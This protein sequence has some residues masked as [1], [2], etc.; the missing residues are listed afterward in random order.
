VIFLVLALLVS[1]TGGGRAP[2][3]FQLPVPLN[4]QEN[5]HWCWAASAQMVKNWVRPDLNVQQCDEAS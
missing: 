4:P 2:K 3:S 5:N 1:G